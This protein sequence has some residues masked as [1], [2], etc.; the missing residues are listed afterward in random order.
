VT[1]CL[2]SGIIAS[3]YGAVGIYTVLTAIG[4]A[5]FV[6]TLCTPADE[7]EEA[8]DTPGGK[9]G[10]GIQIVEDMSVV[11]EDDQKL[12]ERHRNKK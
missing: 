5:A 1:V 10:D 12:T 3:S 2:S 11:T 9:E 4:I 6:T 7:Q 8:S